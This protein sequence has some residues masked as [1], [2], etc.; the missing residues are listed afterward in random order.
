M[1]QAS[2]S[3]IGTSGTQLNEER[4]IIKQNV[5]PRIEKSWV[6]VCSRLSPELF[7]SL[8]E[9][10]KG[11]NRSKGGEDG[12]EGERKVISFESVEKEVE[13]NL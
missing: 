3:T 1:H 4:R 11:T 13:E 9:R 5:S 2:V 10:R 8:Q 7:H 12:G 6:Y